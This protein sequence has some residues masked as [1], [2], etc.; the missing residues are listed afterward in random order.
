VVKKLSYLGEAIEWRAMNILEK[1]KILGAAASYDHSCTGTGL[2]KEA[3]YT[4]EGRK[5]IPGI[6]LA[7]TSTGKFIPLLKVLLSNVCRFNCAYCVNRVSNCVPRSFFEPR[8]LAELFVELYKRG[9][10]KGIFLSSAIHGSPEDTFEKMTEVA[11]ILRK[12]YDFR[13]YIHLKI[14]PGTD[15][16]LIRKAVRL[17]TR[18]SVNLEFAREKSLKAFAPQK[19]K[20][21]LIKHLVEARNIALEEGTEVSLTT[22]VIVGVPGETDYHLLRTAQNLYSQSL[23]KRMYFSAYVPVNHV[24]GLPKA[25]PPF[26]RER[27]LY[28]ADYLIRLY[29]FSYEELLS[30]GEDL[31]LEI[32]PKLYWALRHPEFFPV[33]I[34]RADYYELLRVPGIGPRM[35]KK[36]IQERIRGNLTR[37]YLESLKGSFSKA[38]PF[39]TYKGKAL[40]KGKSCMQLSLFTPFLPLSIFPGKRA[41]QRQGLPIQNRDQAL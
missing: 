34:T 3:P 4:L 40:S 9:L 5:T 15:R 13:G 25:P 36:I 32:D 31:P 6:Y 11:K 22:Q 18:V 24:S 23:I 19:Q 1:L 30:P 12:V 16:E 38:K 26:L 28:Q 33:E 10:V 35:A 37:S 17:A 7:H 2:F 20:R 39:L 8:E 21:V 29:G 41:S 14:L 27:R